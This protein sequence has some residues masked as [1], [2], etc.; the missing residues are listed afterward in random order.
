MSDFNPPI[1][2]PPVLEWVNLADLNID[3][4][5]QRGLDSRSSQDLIAGIT[6]NWDWRLCQPLSVSR[7]DDDSLWVVDGQHRLVGARGRNDIP[8]LPCVIVPQATQKDEAETFIKLNKRRR[9][10]NSVDV[11]KASLAAGN[12]EA[13]EV[14]RLIADAGLTIAPHSNYTAWKPAMIF[15][16]PGIASAY[17]RFGSNV[18][19]NALVALQ[20]A[21]SEQ[22]LRYAGQILRGL[23]M[24]YAGEGK[25]AGFDPDAFIDRLSM[26]TQQQWMR[27]AHERIARTGESIG[28]AI[29][30][31]LTDA[32]KAHVGK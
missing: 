16:V 6:K 31:V 19:S 24:F 27:K 25:K 29:C 11:F 30:G 7:R 3:G 8:R 15:C 22:V 28:P 12:P 26:N 5:Y 32:Y 1:G 2:E 20:E 18:T 23:F 21:F 9:A 4:A 13:T 17:R 14:S 10:L